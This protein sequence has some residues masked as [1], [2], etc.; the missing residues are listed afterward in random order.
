METQTSPFFFFIPYFL[1]HFKWLQIYSSQQVPKTRPSKVPSLFYS[2][3]EP[4]LNKRVVPYTQPS[5]NLNRMT[6]GINIC[7]GKTHIHLLILGSCLLQLYPLSIRK[8]HIS[9]TELEGKK[10][11]EDYASILQ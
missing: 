8:S 4:P 9:D 10:L 5:P 6:R 11:Q 1:I 7:T 3:L 2:S